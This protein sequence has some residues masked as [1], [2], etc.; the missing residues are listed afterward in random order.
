MWPG[1]LLPTKELAGFLA[2]VLARTAN[3]I[4]PLL[5]FLTEPPSQ[6]R[7][8]VLNEKYIVRAKKHFEDAKMPLFAQ[9]AADD[10]EALQ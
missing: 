7:N 5:R 2:G 3:N 6:E 9:L 10:L 4:E 1:P 8:L